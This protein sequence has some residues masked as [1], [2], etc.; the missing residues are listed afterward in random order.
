ML[1]YSEP[2]YE[3]EQ[4]WIS[5]TNNLDLFNQKVNMC[6]NCDDLNRKDCNKIIVV[7]NNYGECLNILDVYTKKYDR[8][9][10]GKYCGEMNDLD[11][12]VLLF[13]D[14][15]SKMKEISEEIEYCLDF[16]GLKRKIFHQKGCKNKRQ[17]NKNYY[18]GNSK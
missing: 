11:T 14:L 13:Y 9:I 1:L 15:N 6:E 12:R 5:F 2:W 17:Y 16:M 8:K 4:K 3:G 10:V 18:L 7:L